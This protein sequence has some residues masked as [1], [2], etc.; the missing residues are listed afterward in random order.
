MFR[1]G[2]I[3]PLRL[4][5]RIN[6]MLH[7]RAPDHEEKATKGPDVHECRQGRL[8]VTVETTASWRIM[9]HASRLIKHGEITHLHL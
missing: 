5:F 7:L 4:L 2:N 1:Q 9:N 3:I 6:H 8:R